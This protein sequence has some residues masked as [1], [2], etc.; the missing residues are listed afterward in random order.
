MELL[1]SQKYSNWELAHHPYSM[2]WKWHVPTLAGTTMAMMEQHLHIF[3]LP[4]L[5]GR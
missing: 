5:A 2:S 3:V 4:S 1:S